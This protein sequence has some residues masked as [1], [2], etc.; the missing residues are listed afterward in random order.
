M[1][2]AAPERF[3]AKEVRSNYVWATPIFWPFWPVLWAK[4]YLRRRD[5]LYATFVTLSKLPQAIGQL[6]FLLNRARGRKTGL[7]EYKAAGSVQQAAGGNGRTA[8]NS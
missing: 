3:R 1:H 7:I 5:A 6:T 2:G 4:I 8:V